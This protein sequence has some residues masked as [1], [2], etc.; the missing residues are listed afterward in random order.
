MRAQDVLPK[1]T[2]Q[3]GKENGMHTALATPSCFKSSY[4][5]FFMQVQVKIKAELGGKA[6]V[7]LIYTIQILFLKLAQ[8][9]FMH[10]HFV[11][12]LN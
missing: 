5:L 10:M 7:S 6:S 8:Y 11:D 2:V 12:I 1:D 9:V 3:K 4:V